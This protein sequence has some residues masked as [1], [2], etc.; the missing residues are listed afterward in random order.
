M[1][2]AY[3]NLLLQV[4]KCLVLITGC[5]ERWATLPFG[6]AYVI[7][8]GSNVSL[9][10]LLGWDGCLDQLLSNFFCKYTWY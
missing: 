1:L 9:T 3:L 7:I 10:M 8:W 6:P 2:L 4:R 5:A